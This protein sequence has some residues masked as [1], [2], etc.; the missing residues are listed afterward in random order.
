MMVY[1]C[2]YFVLFVNVLLSFLTIANFHNRDYR[3]SF[4][5]NFVGSNLF[6]DGNF[7]KKC[8]SVE[9]IALLTTRSKFEVH[10]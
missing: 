3:A 5:K 4:P 2:N 6:G 1:F 8:F 9:D 7:V 10:T